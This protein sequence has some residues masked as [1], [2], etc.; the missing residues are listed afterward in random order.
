[1]QDIWET[2]STTDVPPVPAEFDRE[3]HHRLN[4]RLLWSQ[5]AELVFLV[6]PYALVH[7]VQAVCGLLQFTWSGRFSTRSK[8]GAVEK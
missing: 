2:L 6:V 3:V 7:M 5:V 1:M 8:D 4:D